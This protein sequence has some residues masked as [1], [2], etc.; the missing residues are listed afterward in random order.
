MLRS[1]A[2]E[3]QQL[4]PDTRLVRSLFID[5]VGYLLEALP[6]DL[7][8]EEA[9]SL[10]D[11]LPGPVKP[12]VDN[13]PR[14][15]SPGSYTPPPSY[16][17]RMIATAIVYGFIVAQLV[18]PYARM[19][20][21]T[22]YTYER[23]HRVTERAF[24]AALQLADGV[25]KGAGNIEPALTRLGDGRVLPRVYSL[26]AWTMESIAGGVYDGVSKGIAGL[27]GGSYHA[28]KT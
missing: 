5:G 28:G 14:S 2:Y 12:N 24:A 8:D 18:L 3:A 23:R 4:D 26:T 20:L 17:H 19:L 15:P 22:I 11:R 21:N 9:R 16:L 27:E 10:Y 1:A 6:A 13:T 7:T 25:G